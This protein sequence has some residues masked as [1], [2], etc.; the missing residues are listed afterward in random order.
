MYFTSYSHSPEN[1]YKFLL[2]VTVIDLGKFIYPKDT[3]LLLATES[4]PWSVNT[5]I[6]KT[7]S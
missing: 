3:A 4:Q 7:T 6:E 5:F 1:N 2:K